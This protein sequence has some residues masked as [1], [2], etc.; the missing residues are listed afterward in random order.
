MQSYNKFFTPPNFS[1]K[2][3]HYFF[4][5]FIETHN[6]QSDLMRAAGCV[7]HETEKKFLSRG[8]LAL[9]RWLLD[10]CGMKR[11]RKSRLCRRNNYARS[12][13]R[14]NSVWATLIIFN[15]R[16][17]PFFFTTLHHSIFTVPNKPNR[18]SISIWISEIANG[19]ILC[20]LFAS[21]TLKYI[22]AHGSFI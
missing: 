2:K 8:P 6:R 20:S 11:R 17:V 3:S 9:C 16:A 22:N 7:W 12:K 5:S 4:D 10:F 15:E 13:P 21:H 19:L 1:P 18:Y 14:E